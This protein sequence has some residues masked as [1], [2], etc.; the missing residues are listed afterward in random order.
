MVIKCEHER[1][2]K[3]VVACFKALA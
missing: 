2:Q 3:E 1:M